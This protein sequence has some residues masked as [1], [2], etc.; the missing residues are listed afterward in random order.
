MF[1]DC[2][3]EGW[4]MTA[5]RCILSSGRVRLA[6]AAALALALTA[7]LVFAL[8]PRSIAVPDFSP[9]LRAAAEGL[10]HYDLSLSFDEEAETIAVTARIDYLNATGGALDA[11]VVCTFAGAYAAEETSPAAVDALFDIAYPEGFSAGGVMLMGTWWN[12]EIVKSAYLD[13]AQT[14]LSVEIPTIDDGAR[15]ELTMR[16]LLHVPHCAHRF[17]VMDGIW[18]IG[19]VLPVMAVYQNGAWRTDEY[20]AIG[21][22]FLSECANYTLSLRLPDGY[23]PACTAHL[24]FSDGVWTGRALAVRDMALTFSKGYV[25]RERVQEGTL[26]RSFAATKEG[27]QAALEDAARALSVFS[28]LYGPYPYPV[29]TVAEASFPFDGME[30]P[31]FVMIGAGKYLESQRDSLELVIAHETAHQWFYALVG[32]D[33]VNEPW[34]DEALCEYAMLRYARQRYGRASADTLRAY[35]VEAPMRE[36]IPGDVTPGSPLSHFG[37]YT[38]YS[39]V[40][41][42]RGAALMLALDSYLSDADAFL[43][44]YCEAFAFR[45]ASRGDFLRL[46]NDYAKADLSPLLTDYLDTLME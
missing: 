40:V 28:S 42:G 21:D 14:A 6:L 23:L 46:L 20:H 9:A 3:G 13:D 24:T 15:G 32:S 36:S 44:R 18:H 27:A 4:K 16:L 34:Q 5:K 30:Y 37:D 7:V 1:S 10:T 25:L 33:Q 17:G 19:N 38:A 8:A 39:A 41:Y 45:V 29:F 26:L 35:R 12:G 43:R 31:A 22:P 2:A 11:L